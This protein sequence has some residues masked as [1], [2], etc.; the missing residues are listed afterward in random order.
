LLFSGE[1]RETTERE[2]EGAGIND[3]QDISRT[4]SPKKKKKETLAKN[5][6]N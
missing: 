5:A 4:I 3:V 6:E 2:G 1:K